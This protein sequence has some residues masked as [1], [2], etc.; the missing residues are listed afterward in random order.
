MLALPDVIF[1]AVVPTI[2]NT[3][4]KNP[5]ITILFDTPPMYARD[6]RGSLSDT[7]TTG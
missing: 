6:K 1:K 7:D 3:I 4:L 5:D 2:A